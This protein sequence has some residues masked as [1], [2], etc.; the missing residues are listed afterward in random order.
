MLDT[1]VGG[2]KC[3]EQILQQFWKVIYFESCEFLS[4]LKKRILKLDFSTQS[5]KICSIHFQ[6][7]W[8]LTWCPDPKLW[9]N[10]NYVSIKCIHGAYRLTLSVTM[11]WKWVHWIV[12]T[13]HIQNWSQKIKYQECTKRYTVQKVAGISNG[14]PNASFMIVELFLIEIKARIK[15]FLKPCIFD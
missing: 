4:S 1:I 5:W 14:G 3:V 6:P 7:Q 9:Q 15:N 11:V 10:T 12:L 2:W 8:Y 13:F